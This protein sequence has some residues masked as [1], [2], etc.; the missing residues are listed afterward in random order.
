M[1]Y[2]HFVI[3]VVKQVKI[4]TWRKITDRT[5]DS[6]LYEQHSSLDK[7]RQKNIIDF[8][9]LRHGVRRTIQIAILITVH[10]SNISVGWTL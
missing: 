9:R 3:L 8:T 1:D 5:T 4:N 6:I 10:W 7:L 2:E